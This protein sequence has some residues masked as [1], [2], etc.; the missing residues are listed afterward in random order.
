MKRNGLLAA[1]PVLIILTVCSIISIVFWEKGKSSD[2][3]II[4]H[5]SGMYDDSF[6]LSIENKK[7]G[8]ILYTLNGEE[9]TLDN[10]NS[11]EYTEPLWIECSDFTNTYSLQICC[12]FDDGTKSDVYRRDYIVDI[13]GNERF[14]TTY[15]VSIVGNEEELF[16]DEAGIFVRGNQYYEYLE[17]NPEA[18][19]LSEV[20]PANYFLDIEVPVHAAFFLKNGE[21]IIDQNCGIKISGNT[22]QQNNQKS[23]KLIARYDY[24]EVNEFSYPFFEDYTSKEGNAVIDKFQRLLFHSSG[25]DN[26][27]GYIRNALMGDLARQTGFEEAFT[28]ESVTVYI[29]GKYQGVYWLHNTFDDRYFKEMYG[30]YPGEMVVCKGTLASMNIDAAE[31]DAEIAG[32]EDYNQFC[33]WVN[34]ADLTDEMNWKKVCNTID[35]ENFAHYFALQYYTTNQDWPW[36]NVRIYRYQCDETVGETYQED[37]VFDGRW[38][39]ILFDTDWSFGYKNLLSFGSDEIC[40]R[41]YAFLN[42]EETTILFKALCQRTEFKELFIT[43][44]LT[45]MNTTF[46][47]NNIAATMDELNSKRY[48]ELYHML[49][50]TDLIWADGIWEP[51]GFGKGGIAKTEK[52]WAEIIRYSTYRPI[53]VVD[54]M[55]S[56]FKCGSQ[57]PLHIF[58]SEG[59]MYV[60]NISIG[61]E[62]NGVWVQNIPLQITVD[63]KS[64]INVV[65]Y[66]VNSDYIEGE[67]LVLLPEQLKEYAE[68]LTISPVFEESEVESLIIKEYKINGTQDY[69]I[70]KNDGTVSLNLNNY[71]VSDDE[72][73][74]SKGKLS[75][76]QLNP[77]ELYYV[78]G[79]NYSGEMKQPYI[80]MPFSWND[81]EKVHLFRIPY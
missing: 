54:E 8:K 10:E 30:D 4:S 5:E 68:G 19:V 7:P 79:K 34:T 37:T 28:A 48:D 55:K 36:N 14:S 69:V 74:L 66:M 15:V 42:I 59:S 45:M 81:E 35:I 41:L 33:E 72:N 9:P 32:C 47:Y 64:G 38:R 11:I 52:N 76:Y 12:Y 40:Y 62:M 6:E 18:D 13:N 65:G 78:Y 31:T 53:Y 39:Y 29:N 75:N 3:L 2:K 44:V 70:L 26:G 49:D 58:T 60:R 46:D 57:M 20:I 61:Q 17:Q 50:E 56:I 71:V 23:F 77:D 63:T 1:L 43:N 24:D 25:D 80:Q 27:F 73:D 51:W 67:E 21:Q 22:T 16:G